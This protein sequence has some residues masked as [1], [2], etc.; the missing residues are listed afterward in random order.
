MKETKENI[1]K[2]YEKQDPWGF[3]NN[4]HDILRKEI[5]IEKSLDFCKSV[6][7]KN[8][9]M[10]ALEIG[11]GEGWII[12]DLPAENVYGYELSETAKSRWPSNVKDFDTSLKYDLIIAPADGKIVEI[13]TN[14][15]LRNHATP[16][17][18]SG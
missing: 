15:E 3:K 5:I 7:N 13:T 9:Y 1:E 14:A 8:T 6:L 10:N 16:R 17:H 2:F 11:A 12:K 4:P 18:D